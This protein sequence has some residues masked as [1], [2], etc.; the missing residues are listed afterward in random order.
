MPFGYSPSYMTADAVLQAM[1]GDRAR[2]QQS[3]GAVP[4]SWEA[5]SGQQQTAPSR[6]SVLQEL[7][8]RQRAKI[9]SQ[10]EAQIAAMVDRIITPRFPAD[11]GTKGTPAQIAAFEQAKQD[12]A[13]RVR[14]NPIPFM[15]DMIGARRI[16]P[17]P[18]MD[19]P[20]TQKY[21]EA[22]MALLD[23]LEGGGK[24]DYSGLGGTAGPGHLALQAP[25]AGWDPRSELFPPEISRQINPPWNIV[26]DAAYAANRRSEVAREAAQLRSKGFK[27]QRAADERIAADRNQLDILLKLRG[28][29]E[30][31]VLDYNRNVAGLLDRTELSMEEIEKR[32]GPRPTT[33]RT[34]KWLTDFA[35][36]KRFGEKGEGGLLDEIT[37]PIMPPPTP[38]APSLAEQETEAAQDLRVE[39]LLGQSWSAAVGTGT[40]QNWGS[41]NIG[42]RPSK[43]AISRE[44]ARRVIRDLDLPLETGTTREMKVDAIGRAL[45]RFP[46]LKEHFLKE[47]ASIKKGR[48]PQLRGMGSLMDELRA[49]GYL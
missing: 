41:F 14:G 19:D 42:F 32:L 27:A 45:R 47:E 18:A 20:S 30:A 6:G 38:L 3:G 4:A 46:E 15:E 33:T 39:K 22:R 10:D 36:G 9:A 1:M 40:N 28:E 11:A 48:S 5:F 26:S 35:G 34:T 37:K 23:Q 12:M 21:R 25:A 49:K 2:Q 13:D 29:E 43:E 8:L 44:Q 16:H 24:W 7:P 17:P 31:A